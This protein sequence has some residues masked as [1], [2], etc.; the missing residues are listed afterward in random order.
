MAPFPIQI[1]H[2]SELY[3][4]N[5]CFSTLVRNINGTVCSSSC[6][7]LV[8]SFWNSVG[9]FGSRLWLIIIWSRQFV[10]DTPTVNKSILPGRIAEVSLDADSTPPSESKQR[11]GNSKSSLSWNCFCSATQ[12]VELLAGMAFGEQERARSE[13]HAGQNTPPQRIG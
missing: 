4:R 8:W 7:W 3:S 6:C 2:Y 13:Q 5:L 12:C 1:K 10:N 9:L 11:V